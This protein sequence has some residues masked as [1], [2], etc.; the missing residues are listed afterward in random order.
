M[1]E[2]INKFLGSCLSWLPLS[3]IYIVGYH[4]KCDIRGNYREAHKRITQTISLDVNFSYLK[5]WNVNY[6]SSAARSHLCQRRCRKDAAQQH[7]IP[8]EKVERTRHVTGAQR[9][10]KPIKSSCVQLLHER[11]GQGGL[12]WNRCIDAFMGERGWGP[13]QLESSSTKIKRNLKKLMLNTGPP[14]RGRY[15]EERNSKWDPSDDSQVGFH[16]IS[17]QCKAALK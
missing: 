13:D 14:L 10:V 16:H 15:L 6:V 8:G 12:F 17:H 11:W 3:G 9:R 4:H 5:R 1:V 2:Q 7:W